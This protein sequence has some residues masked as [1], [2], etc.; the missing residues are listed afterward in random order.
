MLEAEYSSLFGQFYVC[1]CLGSWSRQSISEHS[2]G[3]I[4]DT[5]IVLSEVNSIIWVKPKLGYD[6][7]CE[8]SFCNLWNNAACKQ[9]WPHV[10][11]IMMP[12]MLYTLV[13]RLVLTWK[14]NPSWISHIVLPLLIHYIDLFG[15]GI[16]Q[17]W[18]LQWLILPPLNKYTASCSWC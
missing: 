3:C 4:G 15:G 14:T 2:I 13:D 11:K 8:Y 7:K 18:S 10:K 16:P 1:W 12:R 17:N 5:C 9:L 6:W